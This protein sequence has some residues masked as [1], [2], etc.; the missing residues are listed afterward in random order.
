MF[1]AAG[2]PPRTGPQTS[3]DLTNL[4]WCPATLQLEVG[5]VWWCQSIPLINYGGEIVWMGI[6]EIL[7]QL[8]DGSSMFIPLIIVP[9]VR[10]ERFGARG[11]H[12]PNKYSLFN[13]EP[14]S[15]LEF[16][17]QQIGL[18]LKNLRI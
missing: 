18:H 1:T 9:L 11:I 7:Q 2:A 4:A 12:I 3:E 8:V 6:I 14:R 15:Y 5:E 17:N 10:R 16:P 13:G